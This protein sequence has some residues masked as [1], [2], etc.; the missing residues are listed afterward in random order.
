[1]YCCQQGYCKI[2]FRHFFMPQ[3]FAFIN[4]QQTGV[5]LQWKQSF[6]PQIWFYDHCRQETFMWKQKN[7]NRWEGLREQEETTL[8][9]QQ[10]ENDTIVIFWQKTIIICILKALLCETLHL[11]IIIITFFKQQDWDR[12]WV[13]HQWLCTF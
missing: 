9:P 11:Y 4:V 7:Q 5:Q 6:C 3:Q 8:W 2:N 12:E 10:Q 1:M 13:E